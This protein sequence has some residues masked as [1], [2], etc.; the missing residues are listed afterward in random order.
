MSD[1]SKAPK[2]VAIDEKDLDRAAGGM[3][4]LNPGDAGYR[5]RGKSP[6]KAAKACLGYPAIAPKS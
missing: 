5:K 6:G 4:F 3:L 1:K 2:A